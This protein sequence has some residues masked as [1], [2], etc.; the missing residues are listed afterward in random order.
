VEIITMF[1]LVKSE[2][3]PLTLDMAERFRN[4]M[5]SPTERGF[6]EARAKMLREK[7]AAGQLIAFNWA[8][9]KL[10][11]KEYRMNGQHSS[12]V[13]CELDGS[14]PDGLKVHL[15]SYEVDDKEGL[16]L[17][18][19]QFDNR[20]SGRTPTDV[21]GAY[22]GLYEALKDVPRSAAKLAVEGA[23][24]YRRAVEG[25]PAA[26]G[27]DVYTLFGDTSLHSFVRWIGEVF[28][29]KTPE[30]RRM[31]IVGAM[32]GTFVTNETEARKFWREVSR[33]GVEFEDNHP[34]TVLDGFYKAI[35]ED[36]KKLDLKPANLYQA[37]VYAWNAF[38]EDKT[39]SNVKFDTKKGLY[40]IAA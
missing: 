31:M 3:K 12:A 23:N 26:S 25:L 8:T 22:Q 7:T 10:G 32:Y 15:D 4:L 20:K 36:K 27:D 17:L 38:R 29:V 1:R 11:D 21:A 34:T 24:W 18:F 35:I 6:D 16:A 9:A 39:I 37:A 28:S 2:T 14:F 33:G 13:L 5:P 19:R 40:T 30:L